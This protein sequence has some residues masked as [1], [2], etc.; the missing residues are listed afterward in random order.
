M[1]ASW[2]ELWPVAEPSDDFALRVLVKSVEQRM[3]LRRQRRWLL[4]ALAPCLCL[5][6]VFAVGYRQNRTES[7]K[8]AASVEAQRHDT[9]QRLRRLQDDFESASRREQELQASLASAKNEVSRK[10]L[11]VELDSTRKA[12]VS[13]G[14]AMKYRAT[15]QPMK[16]RA[17]ESCAPGDSLCPQ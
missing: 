1:S 9:E 10:Q 3:K 15:S 8:R 4:A 7:L 16:A 5:G 17:W 14:R 12:T 6:F 2:D 11:Q 13:A